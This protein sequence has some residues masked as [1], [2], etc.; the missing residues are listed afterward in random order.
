MAQIIEHL[1]SMHK[2]LSSN[3]C[4][5][6]TKQNKVPGQ[7][8]LQNE[9]PCFKTQNQGEKIPAGWVCSSMAEH[10]LS[11]PETLGLNPSTVLSP[12]VTEG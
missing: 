8:G 12:K 4:T 9:T 3:Y 1:P 2:A 11:M 10:L 6:K 7:P 5:A